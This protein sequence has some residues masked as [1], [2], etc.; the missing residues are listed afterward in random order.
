MFRFLPFAT[1]LLA[2]LA[3]NTCNT[4]YSQ[5]QTRQQFGPVGQSFG[6]VQQSFG[7]GQQSF[8]PVQQ[9]FGPPQQSFG[10]VDQNFG[11]QFG[12]GVYDSAV[13]GAYDCNQCFDGGGA[14]FGRPI[15]QGPVRNIARATRTVPECA[16]CNWG[17]VYLGLFGGGSFLDNLDNRETFVNGV[18]GQL[19]IFEQGFSVDDGVAAGASIGRYFYRQARVEFE[20]TYRENNVD[21]FGTFT[22]ADDVTT[23]QIND[24]LIDSTSTPAAGSIESS[25]V[26]INFL[27]DLKPRTVGCL[28]AYLG[29][30]LGG[31][32]LD[33]DAV[34]GGDTFLFDDTALAF[35][36]I[37]GINYP[38]LDRLDLFTE[39]RYTGSDSVSVERTNADGT[40]DSLGAFRFDSHNVV[41]GLR[42]LR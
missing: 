6:A 9:N 4:C 10:P 35:Q 41:F 7:S 14:E 31:I 40:T 2:A 15:R 26:I 27:F 3:I 24:I 22:F 38:V 19:G 21:S 32:A 1:L 30:G 8:G 28:N 13:S 17:P 11:N 5:S 29:A 16:D 42:I 39:Y 20:Y 37:A 12:G 18:P 34:A 25:S 33:G 36:G 23:T